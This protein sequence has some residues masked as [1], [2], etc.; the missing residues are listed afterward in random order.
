MTSIYLDTN[1][2]I[3]KRR[4]LFS[5]LKAKKMRLML[6]K[7]I[8]QEIINK[9][10]KGGSHD[11]RWVMLALRSIHDQF[12]SSES[13]IFEELPHIMKEDLKH[14]FNTSHKRSFFV[15][16][17]EKLFRD[18]LSLTES[19]IE[20]IKKGSDKSQDNWQKAKGKH[21]KDILQGVTKEERKKLIAQYQR[22]G[23]DLLRAYFP[24]IVKDKDQAFQ[25]LYELFVEPAIDQAIMRRSKRKIRDFSKPKSLRLAVKY[26]IA[27]DW[28]CCFGDLKPT[29][30]DYFDHRHFIYGGLSQLF[31]TEDK[32]LRK[33][34][35][36]TD[37]P[38]KCMSVGEFLGE[39]Q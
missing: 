19:D 37:E 9:Y 3:A 32:K 14:F 16:Q 26:F 23:K 29:R 36:L 21:S 4:D 27:F 10:E 38:A 25:A 22:Q 12:K 39:G 5:A 6:S 31:V 15:K 7:D 28:Q 24:N 17:G 13:A 34:F 33:L 35:S 2:H 8:F 30:G 11:Y 1:V 20:Q 18:L